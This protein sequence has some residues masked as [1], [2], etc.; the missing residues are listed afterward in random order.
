MYWIFKPLVSP[1]T[2]ERMQIVGSGR[3]EVHDALLAVIDADELPRKYGGVAEG[4]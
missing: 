1:A 4:F 2:L 3:H